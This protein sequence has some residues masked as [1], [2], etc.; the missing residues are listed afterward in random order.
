MTEKWHGTTGGY[1]NHKCR[2]DN[3]ECR[4]AWNEYTQKARTR[5]A[6]EVPFEEIPHGLNGYTNYRCKCDTCKAAHADYN[7][8]RRNRNNENLKVPSSD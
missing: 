1:N 4:V 3:C 6:Q 8:N 7:R 2:D 5:R